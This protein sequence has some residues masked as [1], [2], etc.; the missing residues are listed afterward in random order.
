MTKVSVLVVNLATGGQLPLRCA[1]PEGFVC[2][3]ETLGPNRI[4]QIRSLCH[5][6]VDVLSDG[7]GAYLE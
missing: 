3:Y 2:M 4:G 7:S 6:R 1:H 5:V